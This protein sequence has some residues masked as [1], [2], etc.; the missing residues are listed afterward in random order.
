MAP[1]QSKTAKRSATQNKTR[2]IE[3]EVFKDS[4]AR[5]RLGFT[6]NQTEKARVR[7]PSKKDVKKEQQKIRLYGKKPQQKVY[8]EK[9]L[10]IPV[11]N[12]AITPGVKRIRGK[13]GKKFV[14][15]DPE[16]ST[17]INRII[18]EVI[19]K[20]EKRDYSKLEKAQKLEEIRE[21]KKKEIEEK[22]LKKQNKLEDKKSELKNKAS[23]ARQDR[24]KRAKILSKPSVEDDSET[25]KK[26]KVAFA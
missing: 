23:K 1:R 25:P 15:E 13:K 8:D 26:K 21:L 4:Q 12:R 19:L 20:D 2:S 17:Q 14:N 11:L 22:E 7:K 18:N 24:R 10:D 9:D 3:S 5:N 6:S 16:D